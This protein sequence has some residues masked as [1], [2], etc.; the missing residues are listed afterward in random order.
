MTSMQESRQEPIAESA[1]QPSDDTA[2]LEASRVAML[3]DVKRMSIEERLNL[4]ER[5]QRDAA[6]ARGA[7]RVR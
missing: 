4:F 1:T 6:W 2:E 7:G 3:R 5:L